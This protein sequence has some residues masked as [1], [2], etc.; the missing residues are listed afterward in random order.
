MFIT[1]NVIFN[2]TYDQIVGDFCERI[3]AIHDFLYI[4]ILS[5]CVLACFIDVPANYRTVRTYIVR[6]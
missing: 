5:S 6:R 3:A 1:L 4:L 2:V